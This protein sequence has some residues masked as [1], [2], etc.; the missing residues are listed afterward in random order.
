[1]PS[2]RFLLATSPRTRGNCRCWPVSRRT[3]CTRSSPGSR[4]RSPTGGCRWPRD[5]ATSCRHAAPSRGR[6]WCAPSWTGGWNGCIFQRALQPLG[7]NAEA[8]LFVDDNP[9][10]CTEAA[11]LGIHGTDGLRPRRLGV[12]LP[13]RRCGRPVAGRCPSGQQVR[14]D[15][16]DGAACL[17]SP[18]EG[19]GRAAGVRVGDHVIGVAAGGFGPCPVDVAAPGGGARI[20]EGG[21]ARRVT[22]GSASGRPAPV[23]MMVLRSS[24]N[25]SVQSWSSLASA[26]RVSSAGTGLAPV[27]QAK[28]LHGTASRPSRCGRLRLAPGAASGSWLCSQSS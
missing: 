22:A 23:G 8:A 11:A 4:P 7:V 6:S 21:L 24:G 3:P 20:V 16:V 15:R 12:L 13:G 27:P 1:M 18:L 2:G 14:D 25:R 26:R 10:F 17:L 28:P 5:T 9:G 19:M